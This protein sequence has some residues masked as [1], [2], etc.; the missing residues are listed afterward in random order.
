MFVIN[1]FKFLLN[2]LLGTTEADKYLEVAL[3]RGG[4]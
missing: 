3:Q 1:V 4:K 2:S